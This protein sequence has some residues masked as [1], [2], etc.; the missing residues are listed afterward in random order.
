MDEQVDPVD[1]VRAGYDSVSWRYRRDEEPAGEYGPWLDALVAR[2]PGSARVLDV[3]CG[4]GV[5]VARELAH[6]G[7]RVVGVDLSDVQVARAR[8]L[9]PAGEFVCGDI[10]TLDFAE[11]E[12]D[13]VVAFYSLI[14]VPVR[15]QPALLT[16]LARWLAPGGWF[17][18]TLGWSAWTGI[19]PDWLGGAAPMWWSHADVGTYREWLAAA[20][21][22]IESES[23]VPEGDGGH[24]LFWARRPV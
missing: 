12:F 24:S 1:V 3:G 9:V 17:V 2:L 14:H 15:R 10:T 16:S 22:V 13:A 11:S 20:G 6:S 5:P 21:L 18:A 7:H 8:R 19:E 4:C 23:F